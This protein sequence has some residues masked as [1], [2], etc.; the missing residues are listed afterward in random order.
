MFGKTE[1]CRKSPHF[2]NKIASCAEIRSV[3]ILQIC[4]I[5]DYSCE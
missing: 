2:N 1:S 5:K 4:C 3:F